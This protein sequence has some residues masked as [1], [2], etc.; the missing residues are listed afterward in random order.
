[1]A[2][3]YYSYCL[4]LIHDDWVGECNFFIFS[5][6]CLLPPIDD[7]LALLMVL[8]ILVWCI[9]KKILEI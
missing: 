2:I 7:S 1:M 5:A 6:G 3:I 9:N 4:I 8:Y